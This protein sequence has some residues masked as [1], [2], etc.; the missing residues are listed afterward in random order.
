MTEKT[1]LESWEERM[2]EL[3]EKKRVEDALLEAQQAEKLRQD[4]LTRTG[5]TVMKP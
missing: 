3:K 2:T 4:Y 5:R 1:Q